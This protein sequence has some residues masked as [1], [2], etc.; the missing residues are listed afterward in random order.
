MSDAQH[1]TSHTKPLTKAPQDYPRRVLLAVA[2]LSPQIVTETLYALAVQRKPSFVPTEVQLITTEEGAQRAQLSLL[3]PDTGHFRR[4]C[5]DYGLS[6][7]TFG[8]EQIHVLK[9]AQGEPLQD[10]RSP[11]DNTGA[12]DA[13][14]E[15]VHTLAQDEKAAVHVSIAGGRKT[16]GFYLGYALSLYGRQQDRLS[17]VL[18]NAPYESHRDFYYP[19]PKST[20]IHDD[21][22]RRHYD[23]QDAIV[24][25]AEIPF[26]RLREGLDRALMD[27]RMSFSETVNAYQ[28]ALR[29]PTLELHPA[30][31]QVQVGGKSF[32]MKD[33]LFALY[34]MLADRVRL[35]QPGFHW[36]E[37]GD[38]LLNYRKRLVN[39][40]SGNYERAEEALTDN[41]TDDNFN[42]MKA[43]IKREFER[44]LGE[45]RAAPYLITALER[46]PGT[47]YSRFGLKLP[48]SAIKIVEE[49]AA[50]GNLVEAAS[51]TD[52]G[53]HET[54]A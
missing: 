5:A 8:S 11:E 6:N 16:L 1:L 34:W 39:P 21:N 53:E 17:H 42:P 19:T 37:G 54:Q 28:W 30:V 26:V 14:T 27:G 31:R 32:R 12:A 48:P 25:L 18:V 20:L 10:I 35:G 13:I 40:F 2:G 50:N 7:I 52:V 36:S 43:H 24:T 38:E 47:R 41:F 4:L 15:I 46:I 33:P 29:P 45:R 22:R 3:H 23:A 51:K 44:Q 49:E 9:G